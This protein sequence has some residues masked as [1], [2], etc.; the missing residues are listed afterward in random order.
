VGSGCPNVRVNR[1][2]APHTVCSHANAP[3]RDRRR[4]AV[5]VEI[6]ANRPIRAEQDPARFRE[7]AGGEG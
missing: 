5:D 3:K 1:P 2:N 7:E 6:L 4:A